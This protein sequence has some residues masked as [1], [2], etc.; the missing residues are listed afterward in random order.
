MCCSG[1]AAFLVRV[2]DLDAYRTAALAAL[3]ALLR[4]THTLAVSN[5]PALGD[6]AAA[7]MTDIADAGTRPLTHTCARS[8]HLWYKISVCVYVSPSHRWY[9]CRR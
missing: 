3:D 8:S 6:I 4:Q 5:N 7:C 9:C 1:M 2:A